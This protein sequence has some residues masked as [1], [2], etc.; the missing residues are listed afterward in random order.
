MHHEN[1]ESGDRE[2][3]EGCDDKPMADPHPAAMSTTHGI[4]FH[5]FARRRFI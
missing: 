5:Q 4:T 3:H 2:S 1:E